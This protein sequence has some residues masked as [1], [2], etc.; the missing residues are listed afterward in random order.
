MGELLKI[1]NELL[2]A[3]KLISFIALMIA[4]GKIAIKMY[5]G[6]EVEERLFNMAQGFG[7][8][9]GFSYLLSAFLN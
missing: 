1:Q 3:C 9:F 7:A 8:V 5:M 4:G 6:E 2:F